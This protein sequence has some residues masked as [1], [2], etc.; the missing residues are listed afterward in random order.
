MNE[1]RTGYH[2]HPAPPQIVAMTEAA[3]DEMKIEIDR[4]RH[5]LLYLV[6]RVPIEA[7]PKLVEITGYLQRFAAPISHRELVDII[8][9]QD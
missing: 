6:D 1:L 9:D 4:L 7:D 2:F 3:R 5:W 8:N